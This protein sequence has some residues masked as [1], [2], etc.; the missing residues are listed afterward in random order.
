VGIY[1]AS[2]AALE[3]L[4]KLWADEFGALGACV[5][6]AA[7]GPTQT[8]GTADMSTGMVEAIGHHGAG[9]TADPTI[10]NAVTF[11]PPRGQLRQRRRADDRWRRA[12]DQGRLT[13]RLG[14]ED[15]VERREEQA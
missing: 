3:L 1:G 9:R 12:V 11:L 13:H 7:P 10:A 5:N 6:A 2:K 4:T 8:P 14:S 15:G